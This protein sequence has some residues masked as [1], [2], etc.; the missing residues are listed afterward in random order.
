M[1]LSVAQLKR[2]L[3]DSTGKTGNA[4]LG[5]TPELTAHVLDDPI[6]VCELRGGVQLPQR[7]LGKT[8]EKTTDT[9]GN[10]RTSL[11][12]RVAA[13]NTRRKVRNLLLKW[14]VG[15]DTGALRSSSSTLC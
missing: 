2:F 3:L 5:W 10:E 11:P 1:R 13:S 6:D 9:D 12:I 14:I 8:P 4:N 15:V 7:V